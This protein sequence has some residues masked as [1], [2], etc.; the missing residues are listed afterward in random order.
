VPLYKNCGCPS[1]LIAA[2][3]ELIKMV[4]ST[5]IFDELKANGRRNSLESGARWV[6][7]LLQI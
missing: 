4:K 1:G 3:F 5:L 2:Q 6:K 7:Q